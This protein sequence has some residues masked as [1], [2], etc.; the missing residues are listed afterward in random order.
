MQGKKR[1]YPKR[2]ATGSQRRTRSLVGRRSI[3][4]KAPCC[5]SGCPGAPALGRFRAFRVEDSALSERRLAGESTSASVQYVREDETNDEKELLT[6][7]PRVSKVT[8]AT[9][10]GLNLLFLSTLTWLLRDKPVHSVL[11][12]QDLPR[13]WSFHSLGFS[14]LLSEVIQLINLLPPKTQPGRRS[15]LPVDRKGLGWRR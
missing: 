10:V 12:M 6:A 14:E 5:P 1:G 13:Q 11:D 7:P 15:F 9:S 8:N 2:R 4:L 3:L